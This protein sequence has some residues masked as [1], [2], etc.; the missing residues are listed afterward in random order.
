MG[1]LQNESRAVLICT[2]P[3]FVDPHLVSFQS[4]L[5]LAKWSQLFLCSIQTSAAQ[6]LPRPQLIFPSKTGFLG[7]L[8]EFSVTEIT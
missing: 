1:N 6:V 2:K 7:D 4:S 3:T 5:F 8:F